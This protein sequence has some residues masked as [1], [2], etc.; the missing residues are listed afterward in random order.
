MTRWSP[1]TLWPAPGVTV[2]QVGAGRRSVP[3]SPTPQP[4]A[5]PCAGA[6]RRRWDGPAGWAARLSRNGHRVHVLPGEPGPAARREATVIGSRSA[7]CGP[8]PA[9][10]DAVVVLDEHDESFQEERVPTWH[11]R[12][13][14]VE[15]ARRAGVPCLLVSPGPVTVAALEGGGPGASGDPVEDR[16][17]PG[18]GPGGT[19]GRSAG[20][21]SRAG[22][23][24]FS[25]RVAEILRDVRFDRWRC[26]TA[27]GPGPPCWPARRAGSWS[28]PR[29]ASS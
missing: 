18:L 2:V 23:G 24:L 11:A 14:A 9:P 21:R 19:G 15:R 20:A 17:A 22:R 1:R 3:A 16:G 10:L 7:A 25:A 26:S 4:P 5:G 27:E 28:G 12:D 13:V 8:R 6:L 29:T